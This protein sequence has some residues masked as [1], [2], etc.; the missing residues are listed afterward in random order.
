MPPRRSWALALVLLAGLLTAAPAVAK[1]GDRQEARVAGTCSTGATSQL[2]LRSRDGTIAVRFD[3]KRHRALE[4]WRVVLVH[5]RRIAY[6]GKVRTRKS[7]GFRVE[8]SIADFG[9]PDAVTVRANGPRGMTC[10]AS[11]TL[12]G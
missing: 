11:A 6:R 5:E 1:G 12:L 9:G 4:T 3:V 2:R 10:V 7:S 8:R